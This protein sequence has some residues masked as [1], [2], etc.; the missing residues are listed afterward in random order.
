ML[1]TIKTSKSQIQASTVPRVQE[2]DPEEDYTPD[3]EQPSDMYD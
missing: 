3:S 2:T 1:G